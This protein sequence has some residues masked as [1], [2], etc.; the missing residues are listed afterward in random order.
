[1][2]LGLTYDLREDYLALGYSEEETAEFDKP[3]TIEGIEAALHANGHETERV[4]NHLALMSALAAGRRWELVFNI[5]EGLRGLGRESLVPCLLD[6]FDVP[7]TFSDPM[8]LALSLHKGMCKRVLRDLGVPTAPFLVVERIEDLDRLDLGFPLF[9]KPVAEGTGKGIATTSK[10]GDAD[11]LRRTCAELLRKFDQAVLVEEF[12]PGREF[13]V[14]VVGTGDAARAV[15]VM[16]VRFRRGGDAIYSYESKEHYLDLVDY[17]IPDDPGLERAIAEVA[18]ASWRGL[19]CRDGGR[20]D[21]RL[22]GRG[23]PMFMEVNPLAGLNPIDS[24]LPIMCRIIG[25]P[26][27]ELIGEIVRSAAARIEHARRRPA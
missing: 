13:T 6:A 18:L 8:V 11:T 10:I 20:V 4:G 19:G 14:G 5:A 21:L 2:K 17:A 26:Y 23:H 9:A 7:Y 24:D 16:E 12:L 22:D 1:M 25:W 3:V 15:A 27:E